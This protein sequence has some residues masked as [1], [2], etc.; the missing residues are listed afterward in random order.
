[1][2]TCTEGKRR[3]FH[4]LRSLSFTTGKKNIAVNLAKMGMTAEQIA[5]AVEEETAVVEKWL[6]DTDR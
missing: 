2:K 5:K 1:M 6:T 4:C 3:S